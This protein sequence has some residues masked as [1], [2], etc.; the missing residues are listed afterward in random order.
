[1][2]LMS[3]LFHHAK[4]ENKLHKETLHTAYNKRL[5]SLVSNRLWFLFPTVTDHS[6][7][8]GT[9]KAP[10]TM[11][12]RPTGCVRL[13]CLRHLNYFFDAFVIV[14]VMCQQ[15][16]FHLIVT[17][18]I[19]VFTVDTDIPLPFLSLSLPSTAWQEQL[20]NQDGD[21]G[22]HMTWVG[23]CPKV[24]PLF[25]LRPRFVRHSST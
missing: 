19:V 12:G 10:S 16:R 6:N 15:C 18:S 23:C 20:P 25:F 4:V 11:V 3:A 8:V 17:V 22:R 5:S 21:V 1:M 9:T 24:H 7:L 14:I 13:C 2:D